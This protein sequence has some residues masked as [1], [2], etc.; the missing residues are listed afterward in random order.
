MNLPELKNQLNDLRKKETIAQTREQLLN[1]EKDKLLSEISSLL[2][3]INKLEIFSS[4]ELNTSNLKNI[5][6]KLGKHIEE[7]I[8]K[9]NLPPELS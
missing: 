8:S 9:S 1:E 6:E 4:E 5:I 3:D 7:E 2:I